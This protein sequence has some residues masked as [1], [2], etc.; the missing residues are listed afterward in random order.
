MCVRGWGVSYSSK[1]EQR[2]EAAGLPAGRTDSLEGKGTSTSVERSG[3][4]QQARAE[5]K[6]LPSGEL[7]KGIADSR[8][9]RH[10]Y[11]ID[12]K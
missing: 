2:A 12:Q 10:T 1:R 3:W 5:R 7:P 4:M 6:L 8:I 9:Q 11:G